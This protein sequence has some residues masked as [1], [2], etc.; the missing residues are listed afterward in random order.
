MATT[1]TK[2]DTHSFTPPSDSKKLV[3]WASKRFQ[4]ATRLD[5]FTAKQNL[6]FMLGNQ[7]IKWDGKQSRFN[8]DTVERGDV[9]GPVHVTVNKIGGHCERTIARLTKQ[10]P[11]P[12][13]RPVT[14]TMADV[15]AAKVSTRILVHEMERLEFQQSLTELYFW[16]LPL[17]WSFFHVRWDPK[18]GP[19]VGESS[20]GET[21]HK[22]E[23]C[24]E[25]VPAFEMRVDP[26]ARHWREAR[27]CIRTVAM[28]K[29]AAY[30]QYGVVPDTDEGETMSSEWRMGSSPFSRNPGQRG[31][32]QDENSG[33]YIAVH[34]FWM[35]PGGRAKPE[36]TVF[37]WSGKTVLEAPQPFTYEH[38]LLPFEPL[39]LLPAVGGDPAGRTWVTD[40]I[41]LQKDYNDSRS[42]EAMIRRTLTPKIVVPRGG[43]DPHR[44]TSR[45]E[46]IEYN[47]TAQAP[48]L[49]MPDGR[50][51]AQFESGMNRADAEMG[52]RS[53]QQDVSQGKAASSAAAATVM[54]LQEAD[55]TMLAI[56]TKELASTVKRVGY[57][58]LML[59]KQFWDEERTVRTWSR[60]G[61]L[62]VSQFTGADIGDRL[63][64]HVSSESSLPRSKAAQTQLAIDLWSQGVV[65]DPRQ[66]VN[67]LDVPGADF[68]LET[69]N[70]DAKQAER[71]HGPL[72]KGEPVE[73]APWENHEVHEAKHNEFR[74]T[75]EYEQLEPAARANFDAHVDVHSQIIAQKAM[76]MAM[77]VMPGA[78]GAMAEPPQM[79]GG[80]SNGETGDPNNVAGA[81]PTAQQGG[82]PGEP[83]AVPGIPMDQQQALMGN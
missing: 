53:G 83:G 19:S 6:S 36:G 24:L 1:A 70:L 59:V 42:R 29:E 46:I 56:S 57:Q 65:T 33:Q 54:A 20:T 61:T 43:I 37:T 8:A 39:N 26:N 47:P 7:W 74:K 44:L 30:D 21:L 76:S 51:M 55:E 31:R 2:Q 63:D 79:L 23:I 66:F 68:L 18:A 67:M 13:A 12:T 80:A 75:E 17:G 72:I 9:N 60:D 16:V 52:D 11:E 25:Q 14:D 62:E 4:D 64:V 3:A 38:G 78:D 32:T 48:R 15:N 69:M 49:D 73:V 41:P 45:V 35:R 50:W 71:E 28:T 58:I 27:W 81:I 22:G 40:L 10:S 34:Q 77:G 82:N 5:E